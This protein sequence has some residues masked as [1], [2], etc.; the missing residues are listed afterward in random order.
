MLSYLSG[1]SAG[2]GK[3]LLG[4][5]DSASIFSWITKYCRDNPLDHMSDAGHSLFKELE[6][7]QS[8]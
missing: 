7:R 5:I 2:H 8:R 1:L 4:D 6:K 3:S